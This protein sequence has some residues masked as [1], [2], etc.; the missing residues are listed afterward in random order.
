MTKDFDLIAAAINR[1]RMAS[2]IK[3]G[4][5]ERIAKAQA[6][7]LA[8]IDISATLHHAHPRFNRNRFVTLCGFAYLS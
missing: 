2:D 3:G 8:A 5:D 1:S 7:R 6:L 4:R